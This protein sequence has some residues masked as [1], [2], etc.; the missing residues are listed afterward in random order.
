M[1]VDL[2][3]LIQVKITMRLFFIKEMMKVHYMSL[4]GVG[5]MMLNGLIEECV[6]RIK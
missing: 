3:I 5:T 1:C 2:E 4:R 6:L